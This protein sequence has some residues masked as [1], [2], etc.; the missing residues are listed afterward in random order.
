MSSLIYL[1]NHITPVGAGSSEI[2]TNGLVEDKLNGKIDNADRGAANGV[3]P[4]DGDS[5]V[6][7]AYLPN[8]VV[9]TDL[10]G[11][12]GVSSLP[13]DANGVA[14]LDSS[15]IVPMANLSED[16]VVI[17]GTG[18]IP[19]G[20]L[21]SYVDDVIEYPDAASFPATG[22]TGK[23]YIAADTGYVSR[24]S[25][26]VYALVGGA[27]SGAF[28]YT[29]V[30]SGVTME[31]G[32]AY[33][34]GTGVGTFSVTLPANPAINDQIKIIDGEANASNNNITVLRNGNSV[35]G[36]AEDLTVDIDNANFVLVYVNASKGW[37]VG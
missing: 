13:T 28:D 1:T 8:S 22:E 14:L 32:S 10:G 29:Y 24:W 9:Y 11:K 21:P 19:V 4:L 7:T 26:S 27:S 34:I 12:I 18:K 23:I 35:M 2:T 33:I 6:P 25:G 36:L 37:M 5:K 16:I 31:A 30:T 17:D 3:A 15:G 20:Q